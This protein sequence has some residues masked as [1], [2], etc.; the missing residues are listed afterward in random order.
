MVVW[1]TMKYLIMATVGFYHVCLVGS[2]DPD[3]HGHSRNKQRPVQYS[4]L[5]GP[6]FVNASDHRTA[7]A[8]LGRTAHLTCIIRNLHNY[9][10]SWVRARDI[11]L[12]TAG[13]ITYSSDQRFVPSNPGGGEKWMLR[14]HHV[15]FTD[16]GT[17]LCQ[18]S[19]SLPISMAVTLQVTEPIAVVH[20]GTDVFLK[21][22]SQVVLVCEVKGCPGPALPAWYRS[23]QLQD[24]TSIEEGHIYPTTEAT[25][26]R[27]TPTD[28]VNL[29]RISLKEF[30]A[31]E[32]YS[33]ER[34]NA[35]VKH[36]GHKKGQWRA[37]N[38]SHSW[39]MSGTERN[40][41][42]IGRFLKNNV[43]GSDASDDVTTDITS[44]TPAPS[45]RIPIARATLV[46]T[47]AT[48]AHSGVYTCRNSCTGPVNLTVHVLTG[49]EE[50][51]A[52][53]HL[54]GSEGL[55]TTS[56]VVIV[57]SVTATLSS[58]ILT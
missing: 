13:L 28:T 53:Q 9:T 34:H 57:L 43:V 11:H 4:T 27:S 12:L 30:L 8:P 22:G 37:F 10:V 2:R 3:H 23:Y 24:G 54:S 6:S 40:T 56:I 7:H 39:E 17:Y 15:K 51:A 31:S 55:F 5:I 50:P 29:R 52:M 46:R 16:S 1:K 58:K 18:I 32:Y 48:A 33:F 47:H 44:T 19:L 45:V 20:P 49:E 35:H 42:L 38:G 26:T 14:I 21:A 41:K 25:T 36:K